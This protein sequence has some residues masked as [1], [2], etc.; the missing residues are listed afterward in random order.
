MGW[1]IGY[2]S[3]W[4]R[5]IGY[6]V[7]AICDH[8][9]CGKK[10]DR[11]LS[12]VCGGEPYG[13]DEGCGLYFCDKH[14]FFSEKT[15][16]QLCKRCCD[17]KKPFKPTP[18]SPVWIKHK[19]TDPSWARWRQE[20]GMAGKGLKIFK[21][22]AQGDTLYIQAKNKV[23]ASEYL[24]DTMGEIPESLLTWTEVK[25]LPEGEELL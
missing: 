13:G 4:H 23:A 1:S 11:G 5:D 18:D 17:G 3:N 6:G 16:A 15:A 20:Q 22:E 21:V 7:P 19:A 25:S 8:P 14:L 24:T 12:Y 9:K 2:D 10:I